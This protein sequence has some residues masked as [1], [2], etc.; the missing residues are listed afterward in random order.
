VFGV[1]FVTTRLP[2]V[3][4]GILVMAVSSIVVG[5]ILAVRQE[6]MRRLLAFSSVGQIGYVVLG[7]VLLNR[8]GVTGGVLHF[9]SHAAAKGALFAVAG[10][11]VY[12]TGS[13][14]VAD[15]AGLGRRAPWTGAVLTVAGLSLVG[16]PLTA[17]FLSKIHLAMGA[18]E[19]RAFVVVPA[20]LFSSLLTAIYVGRMVSLVW[21]APPGPTPAVP[22][23]VPWSM[24]LPSLVLA[25]ACVLLG[26]TPLGVAVARG[27]AEAL[28]R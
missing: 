22:S 17:G 1:A 25:G 21:F 13:S 14:R 24:R 19:A 3:R 12:H 2:V 18:L 23:E 20:L 7:V 5:P 6:D 16:V 26:T 11:L 10:A 15:L 8:D 28:L 9:W 4:D 27:A